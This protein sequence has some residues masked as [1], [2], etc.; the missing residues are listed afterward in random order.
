MV[1]K[2]KAEVV[3]V[4]TAEFPRFVIVADCDAPPQR[5][6]YWAGQKWISQSHL[7][8]LYADRNVALEDLATVSDGV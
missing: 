6:R 4:G 8:L 1:S 7:A 2:H 3:S 5:R